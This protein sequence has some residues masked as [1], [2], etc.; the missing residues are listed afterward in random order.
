VLFQIASQLIGWKD[1]E[2]SLLVDP[3]EIGTLERAIGLNDEANSVDELYLDGEPS[4]SAWQDLVASPSR[5][6]A[7]RELRAAVQTSEARF[8][9]TS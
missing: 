5:A 1:G 7:Q 3:E 6:S 8:R 4:P 2:S 9:A